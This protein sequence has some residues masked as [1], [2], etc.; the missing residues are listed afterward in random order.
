MLKNI[1]ALDE[2]RSFNKKRN[3]STIL[4]RKLKWKNILEM[5]PNVFLKYLNK[6]QHKVII[7]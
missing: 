5:C 1:N 4:C 7:N 6:S 3:L 2:D